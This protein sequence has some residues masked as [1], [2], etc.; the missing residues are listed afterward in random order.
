METYDEYEGWSLHD[1]AAEMKATRKELD[2]AKAE[3]TRLQNQWDYL[4]KQAIP[5]KMESEG[6]NSVSFKGIGRVQLGSD[7]YTQTVDP[8]G[9]AKW[10]HERD[11][12]AL[13]K[14]SVNGSSLKSLI[15][16]RIKNG[17][18][19]PD[20]AVKITPFTRASIVS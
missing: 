10:L 17:E 1:L 13:I 3:A 18:D 15:K 8:E 12:D 7:M 19:I 4:R 9:L 16:E 11:C 20:E 6:I 5:N 2:V 14:P